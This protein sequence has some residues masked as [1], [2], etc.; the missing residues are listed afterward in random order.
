MAGSWCTTCNRS[1]HNADSCYATTIRIPRK[2]KGKTKGTKGNY[3]NRAWKSQNFP[4]G[5]NSDQ[6]NPVLHDVSSSSAAPDWWEDHELGSVILHRDPDEVDPV[7]PHTDLLD[8]DD[9]R[10][11]YNE[12]DDESVSEYI[13]LILLAIVSN[14]E[15]HKTYRTTPTDAL[16]VEINQCSA[17][18]TNAE[19]C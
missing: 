10:N 2:G 4:A 1:G 13:D 5:Y 14:L 9:S 6:A 15:R 7:S 11:A 17:F 12:D 18:I 19:N 16:L 8:L 3:G